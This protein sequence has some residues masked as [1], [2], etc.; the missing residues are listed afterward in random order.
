MGTCKN[1]AVRVFGSLKHH[2]TPTPSRQL[3]HTLEF[4]ADVQQKVS[5][6]VCDVT[7]AVVTSCVKSPSM[8]REETCNHVVL[9]VLSTTGHH[10]RPKPGLSFQRD[11][12]RWLMEELMLMA[13][14]TWEAPQHNLNRL[15]VSNGTDR[16]LGSVRHHVT[17]SVTDS[18][19]GPPTFHSNRLC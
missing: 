2:T 3:Q 18:N 13:G 19:R 15:Y 9:H 1:K 7:D 17:A 11:V 4:V 5:R 16:A 14:V 8:W 10:N 6:H 12:C